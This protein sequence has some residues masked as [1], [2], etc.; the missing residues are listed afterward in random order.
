M[1][2]QLHL[3]ETFMVT[4]DDGKRHKVLAYERLAHDL[5]FAGDEQHWEPT[6]QLEY[7]L[8]DGRL[9]EAAPDGVLRIART[10][11]RLTPGEPSRRP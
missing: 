5:T 9:V 1:D 4:G 11:E 7:R 8:E 2:L 6:G 3:L 10:G